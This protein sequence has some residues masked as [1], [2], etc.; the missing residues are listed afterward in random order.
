VLF[1]ENA[2]CREIDGTPFCVARDSC[3]TTH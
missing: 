3:T 1:G 2:S